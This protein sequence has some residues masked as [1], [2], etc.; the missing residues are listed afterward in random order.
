MSGSV[1]G[2]SKMHILAIGGSPRLSGNSNSLLRLAVEGAE[3]R[4]ATADILY[5][6]QLDVQ[7]CLGCD[8]WALLRTDR[9]TRDGH[10]LTVQLAER[11]AG[12]AGICRA[13]DPEQRDS[14]RG[15]CQ[16]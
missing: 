3:Q 8:G 5:A 15:T 4:G 14:H 7:G 1:V 6:R 16:R 2:G 9:A 12:L 13:V 11:E 10:G